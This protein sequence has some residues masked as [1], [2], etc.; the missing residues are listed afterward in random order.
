MYEL[1]IFKILIQR[2]AHGYLITKILNKIIGPYAK[3]SNGRLYP[4][5]SRLEQDGLI[6]SSEETSDDSEGGRQVRSYKITEAG[7]VR[8]HELMLDT[9]SNPGDYQKIFLQKIAVLDY[10][11]AEE[12]LYLFDHYINYCQ[13]HVLYLKGQA[14]EELRIESHHGNDMTPNFPENIKGVIQHRIN[15]WQLELEWAKSLREKELNRADQPNL[16]HR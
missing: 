1:I 16:Q 9:T 2:P 14:E 8:F 5:L 7:R 6:E 3:M 10:L 11:T 15:Q 12:R 4:L 13:N